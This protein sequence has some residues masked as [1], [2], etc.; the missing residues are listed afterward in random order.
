MISHGLVDE[1]INITPLSKVGF[2]KNI[3]LQMRFIKLS[4]SNHTRSL[5]YFLE[6]KCLLPYLISQSLAALA[7]PQSS[8]RAL[9]S[10]HHRLPL[11]RRRRN[12][13]AMEHSSLSPHLCRSRA[14]RRAL[15]L[16]IKL[17]HDARPF[18]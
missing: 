1:K 15:P 11:Q 6:E 12:D 14:T 5:E 9:A 2:E 8:S 18:P 7:S 16:P 13:R 10:P 4:L 3:I 17:P